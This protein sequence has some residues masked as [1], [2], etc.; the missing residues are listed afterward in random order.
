MNAAV[1]LMDGLGLD[2]D[3]CIGM[4]PR[5]GE[6]IPM[7]LFTIEIKIRQKK[8]KGTTDKNGVKNGSVN[9]A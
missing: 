8:I 9:I 5:Q 1:G 6:W 4:I 2:G 7:V 3:R